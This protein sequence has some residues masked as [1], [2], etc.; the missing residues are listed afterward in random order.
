MI[1]YLFNNSCSSNRNST[2]CQLTRAQVTQWNKEIYE[3]AINE[4]HDI[5]PEDSVILANA[6][7]AP[8]TFI[9]DR[10]R[11]IEQLI[12]GKNWKRTSIYLWSDPVEVERLATTFGFESP[13][14][15]IRFL[16]FFEKPNSCRE[17]VI[18]NVR[19]RVYAETHDTL[20]NSMNSYDLLQYSFALNVK[21]YHTH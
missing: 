14:Y 17:K 9:K 4:A 7:I 12:A 16:Q 11:R 1:I 13:F 6:Q 20:V 3:K 2:P 15:F 18:K 10:V 5:S 19:D 8:D 21:N